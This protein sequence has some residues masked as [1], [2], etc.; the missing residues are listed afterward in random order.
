[1]RIGTLLFAVAIFLQLCCTS[2]PLSGPSTEEGNPQIIAVVI[3]NSKSV[4]GAIVTAYIVP[5]I[6][7]SLQIPSGATTAAT[8][9]TDAHGRC[10]F[11]RLPSGTYS[12]EATDP[13]TNRR[14]FSAGITVHDAL[15]G[16]QTDTLQLALPGIIK[17]VVSRGGVPGIVASQNYKLVDAAIM[18]IIQETGQSTITPPTGAYTFTNIPAGTYTLIYYATDGFFSAKRTVVTGA[19]STITAD[20][21]TLKPVPRLLPP[22]GCTLTYKNASAGDTPDVRI[23][24]QK[25]DFDSLRWYEVQR[26]DLTGPFDTVF[27][28][29]DTFFIDTLRDIPS[30]TLL[31]Y[32]VCSVNRAF[33]KSANA[34]PFEVVVE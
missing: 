14:A 9:Y 5:P 15:P 27:T 29:V 2:A 20:T 16:S 17:G 18:V 23:T 3:D 21:V 13:R 30:G 28:T 32:V 7:D 33:D 12:I 19:G 1:M 25:L 4:S 31:N 10:T 22:G 24:W 26:Y 11:Y 8:G 6:D 34:G